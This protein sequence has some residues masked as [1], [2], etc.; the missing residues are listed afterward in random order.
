MESPTL[1]QSE[2]QLVSGL[3]SVAKLMLTLLIGV[4]VNVVNIGIKCISAV[5][6]LTINNYCQ[7]S[8]NRNYSKTLSVH[9]AKLDFKMVMK[10][11]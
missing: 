5:V 9:G 4:E 6:S 10:Y 7:I 3:S 2:N 8:L 1:T 11:C